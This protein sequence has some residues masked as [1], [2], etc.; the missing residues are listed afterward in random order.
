MKFLIL[1]ST[2]LSLAAG[3]DEPGDDCGNRFGCKESSA[4]R[5]TSSELADHIGLQEATAALLLDDQGHVPN[6]DEV[7]D[8][9]LYTLTDEDIA[10][11]AMAAE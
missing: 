11:L 4:Q 1:I 5:L 3:C 7:S 6:L 9:L 10:V 8:E 2:V